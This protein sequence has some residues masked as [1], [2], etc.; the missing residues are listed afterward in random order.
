MGPK[1]QDLPMGCTKPCRDGT[2]ELESCSDTQTAHV[3]VQDVGN[4]L[5]IPENTSVTQNLPANGTKPCIGEPKRLESPTDASDAYTRMQRVADDSRRPTDDLERVR[6]SQKG[7]KRSNLPAKPLKSCPEEPKR[8][9]NRAD[10]SSGRTH[11]Q[12]DWIDAKTT[13]RKAEV[14]SITPNKQKPP[15]SPVG[16]G[17]WCRNGTNDLG[18]VADAS[19]T[20]RDVH[21]NRNGARTTAKTHKTISK[22]SNKP[23][24]P[25]L[26]VG[27]NIWC[28]G[29]ADGW[30]NHADGSDVCRDTQGVETD[31]KTAENANGKVKTRQVRPRRPNSPCRVEIEMDKCPERCKHVSNNGNDAYAPKDAPIKSLGT[32]NRKIV[33]GR[34]AEVLGNLEGVEASVEVE[35]AGGKDGECDGDMDGTV[36]GGNDDSNRIEA[37]RLAAESQQTRNNARTQRN[38][39]PVSPG[40]PA[41]PFH[42]VPRTN[43]RRRRITLEP[44]NISQTRKVKIAYLGRA[45]AIW[46]MW[47]PGNRIGWPKNPVA[48]CKSQGECRR[49]VEDYG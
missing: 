42:G 32:R 44:R 39:L 28:I 33:F 17:P 5:N 11:V 37:A 8:P 1:P 16:A 48:E 20:R 41:N 4:K 9:G 6:K 10:A 18:N 24:P 19:T 38:D 22:T 29:E 13:A 26:P 36:S 15:N 21:S 49:E 31:A 14:I 46:S 40:Q 43:C 3:H 25:N 34:P 45:N 35:M 30:G 27:T 47:R 23:K 2:D 7:C 12:S